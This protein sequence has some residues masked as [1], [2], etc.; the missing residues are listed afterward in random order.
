MAYDLTDHTFPAVNDQD[1]WRGGVNNN[2]DTHDYILNEL[3]SYNYL[4]PE[5][6]KKLYTKLSALDGTPD[7]NDSYEMEVDTTS[8]DPKD[9]RYRTSIGGVDYISTMEYATSGDHWSELQNEL[10]FLDRYKRTAD[11]ELIK[12]ED[13]VIIEPTFE[14]LKQQR[15]DNYNRV[16]EDGYDLWSIPY[17]GRP[18]K[19]SDIQFEALYQGYKLH[20]ELESVNDLT[21][22]IVDN[23]L[24]AETAGMLSSIDNL[25]TQQE[26]LDSIK[27]NMEKLQEPED[28]TYV[29]NANTA[30][31]EL[32]GTITQY[33]EDNKRVGTYTE[34]PTSGTPG[35]GSEKYYWTDYVKETHTYGVVINGK[36]IKTTEGLLG[37]NYT[38]E[39][40]MNPS[41]SDPLEGYKGKNPYPSNVSP[42]V[43]DDTTL[44]FQSGV[45]NTSAYW[46]VKPF[47]TVADTRVDWFPESYNERYKD[48]TDF[49]VV[50]FKLY[51]EWNQ[52]Y[53][54]HHPPSSGYPSGHTEYLP[55][56]GEYT[57]LIDENFAILSDL[58][59]T[60]RGEELC[61]RYDNYMKLRED[62]SLNEQRDANKGSGIRSSIETMIAISVIPDIK[63][64][65]EQLRS[66]RK[67]QKANFCDILQEE[68]W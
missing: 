45:H 60:V 5:Q 29:E 13:D 14:E 49:Q 25:Q 51:E 19:I 36:I 47:D 54:V 18:T 9:N 58:P 15:I 21:D 11:D 44:Q 38:L 16:V 63:S 65:Q 50:E 35:I 55:G 61:N 33:I 2:V 37:N 4:A 56:E 7:P 26:I 22:K 46:G 53:E 64:S 20:G 48:T 24:D 66:A 67:H 42:P 68:S 8:G 41:T 62:Q 32:W 31:D 52:G 57:Y 23:T 59:D 28:Y 34:T 43:Y 27:E 39:D 3:L 6:K 40:Y 1:N 12:D 10:V 17:S 30:F